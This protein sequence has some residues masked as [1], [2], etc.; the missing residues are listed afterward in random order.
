M[1]KTNKNQTREGYEIEFAD[2]VKRTIFPLSLR[3]VRELMDI[4]GDV[5]PES[6]KMDAQQIDK[7]VSSAQIVLST[8]DEDLAADEEA[9]ED[10]VD[11]KSWNTMIAVAM[12]TDPNA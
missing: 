8:V 2:G 10:V 5:D 4:I 12:G 7:M 6:T 11:L 1:A 3:K 9:I